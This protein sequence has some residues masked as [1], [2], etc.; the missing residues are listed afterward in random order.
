MPG[1]YYDIEIMMDYSTG[2]T[3]MLGDLTPNWWIKCFL[4][5]I[6]IADLFFYINLTVDL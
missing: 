1:K 4:K 5:E 3:I 6:G 2:Q